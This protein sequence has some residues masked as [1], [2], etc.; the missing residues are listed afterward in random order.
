MATYD[1]DALDPRARGRLLWNNGSWSLCIGAGT[2]IGLMPSWRTL[3]FEVLNRATG[4]LELELPIF[5]ELLASTGWQFD[6]WI[7]TAL[8]AWLSTGRSEAEFG[9]MLEEILYRSLRATAKEDGVEEDLAYAFHQAD[10]LKRPAQQA[11][12]DFFGRRFPNASVVHLARVL[13][14][15]VRESRPPRAVLTFNYDTVLETLIRTAEILE[16]RESGKTAAFRRITRPAP[17]SVEAKIPI[18]HLHGCLTPRPA[19]GGV[20]AI[21]RKDSAERVVATEA[22][23][24]RLAASSASWPQTTFLYHAQGDGLVLIGHSLA[25]PNLRRWLLWATDAVGRPSKSLRHVWLALR[26]ASRETAAIMVHS[27]HH[28]GVVIGWLDSWSE[29]G[30]A[31]ENLIALTSTQ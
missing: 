18:Y 29:V 15:S 8:N 3:A 12:L 14:R 7:Q 30:A 26:P 20:R 13:A 4:N 28:L 9:M 23:Y 27:V 1:I 31:L 19:E 6:A 2:S 11:L 10:L 25:D 24:L 16:G 17:P 5:D 22:T 21:F